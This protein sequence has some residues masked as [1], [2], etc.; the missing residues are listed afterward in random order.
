[1][2]ILNDCVFEIF[3]SVDLCHSFFRRRH[4]VK[5]AFVN[6]ILIDLFIIYMYFDTDLLHNDLTNRPTP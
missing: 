1:M 4:D 6:F 5:N 3:I 2:Y